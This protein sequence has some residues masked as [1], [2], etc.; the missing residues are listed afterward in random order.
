MDEFKREEEESL[1]L[2]SEVQ[3]TELFKKEEDI[4]ESLGLFSEVQEQEQ[5]PVEDSS[6]QLSSDVQ[7]ANQPLHDISAAG[8][9]RLLCIDGVA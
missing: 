2:F 9:R 3:E 4:D 1:G 8:H 5:R 6:P 7:L